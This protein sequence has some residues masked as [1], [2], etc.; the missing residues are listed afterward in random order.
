MATAPITSTPPQAQPSPATPAA[1]G[2]SASQPPAAKPTGGASPT[3]TT[4][5]PDN[6]AVKVSLSDTATK[7][8][9]ASK[10]ANPDGTV[11][12]HHKPRHPKAITKPV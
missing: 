6:D 10:K 1:V 5:K 2:S 12:P 8:L 3:S 4:A 11:G 7:L 9:A